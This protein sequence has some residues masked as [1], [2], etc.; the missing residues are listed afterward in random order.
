M[1]TKQIRNVNSLEQMY[2]AFNRGDIE[3]A[4]NRWDDDITW[5]E[6]EGDPAAGMHHGPEEV[7]ENVFGTIPD[8]LDRFEAVPDR[9]IE[10][11]DTVVVEGRFVITTG[12]GKEYEIPFVHVCELRDGKLQHFTNYTDTVVI[13]QAYES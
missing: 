9:F 5:I 2:T 13:R 8:T 10:S 3:A 11:G 4:L 12:S 6:P 7:L 1:E